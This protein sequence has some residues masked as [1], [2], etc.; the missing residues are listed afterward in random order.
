MPRFSN[1]LRGLRD[2]IRSWWDVPPRPGRITVSDGVTI[3]GLKY[4]A[5]LPAPGASD[6]TTRKFSITENG[7]ERVTELPGSTTETEFTVARDA[8]VSLKLSDVDGSGNQSPWSEPL[9]FTATDTVPPPQPG[10]ISIES[11]GQDD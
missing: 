9:D 11:L 7:E 10:A 4:K 3:M 2:R 8:S 1:W 6:V 5:T